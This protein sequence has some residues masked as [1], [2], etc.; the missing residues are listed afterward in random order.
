VGIRETL[1]QNPG[2]TTGVTAGIIILALVLI[3]WSNLSG[4]GSASNGGSVSKLY[5]S[6]D[7]GKTWYADDVSKVPPYDHN[8]KQAV[9]AHVYKCKDGKLFVGY[10]EE[11]NSDY[12]TK[13]EK[14]KSAPGGR[15]ALLEDA[16]I[17]GMEFKK[18]G[19]N[20]KWVRQMTPD[21]QKVLDVTCPDG[22]RETLEQVIP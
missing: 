19:P 15:G 5:Y 12:R 7:D 10:L 17:G 4:G 16:M 3:I 1:N 8:G 18:P 20:N 9:R 6:D 11:L 2:L 22:S 14:A 21:A 13:L